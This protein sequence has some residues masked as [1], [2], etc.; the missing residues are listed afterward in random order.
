MHTE[1]ALLFFILYLSTLSFHYSFSLYNRV[2]QKLFEFPGKATLLI[3]S[4]PWIILPNYWVHIL[5]LFFALRQFNQLELYCQTFICKGF[6]TLIIYQGYEVIVL[7]TLKDFVLTFS[8]HF[9]FAY[10]VSNSILNSFIT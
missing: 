10:K 2:T 6:C 8:T 5:N 9:T 7:P 3:W 4:L 1:N